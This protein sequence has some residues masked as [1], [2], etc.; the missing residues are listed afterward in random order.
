MEIGTQLVA[1]VREHKNAEAMQQLYSPDIVSVEAGAPPGGDPQ[2]VGLPAC[3]AK[4]KTWSESNAV[5]SAEIEGPFPHGDRFAVIF[6]YDITQ[7]ASGRRMKMNEVALFTVKA[8]KIVRE[9]FFYAM[10]A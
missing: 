2:T 4:S 8:D 6:R 5:H 1:L 10:G 9:E 7:K 3:L